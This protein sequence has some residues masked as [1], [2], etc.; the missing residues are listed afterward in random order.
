M[1]L[2]N[3]NRASKSINFYISKQSKR[4]KNDGEILLIHKFFFND[5]KILIVKIFVCIKKKFEKYI[6]HNK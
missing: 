2:K 3:S 6:F 1:V 5:F 4:E